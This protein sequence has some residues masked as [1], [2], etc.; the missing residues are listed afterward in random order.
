MPEP[1]TAIFC[2][3]VEAE[4]KSIG[5]VRPGAGGARRFGS[6]YGPARR[7]DQSDPPARF[8]RNRPDARMCV[9]RWSGVCGVARAAAQTGA[10]HG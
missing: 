2:R 1:I 3:R 9:E 7:L 10:R 5:K 4:E 8:A 6:V